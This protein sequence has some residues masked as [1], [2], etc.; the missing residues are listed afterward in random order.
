RAYD[1]VPQ[2]FSGRLYHWDLE[3]ETW[4]RVAIFAKEAGHTPYPDDL[5]IDPTGQVHLLWEWADGGP[6]P[7]RYHGSYLTYDPTTGEFSDI[8]DTPLSVPV[9]RSSGSIAYETRAGV[10]Q[11]A[12]MTLAEGGTELVGVAYRYRASSTSGFAVNWAQWDGTAW[13]TSE[14]ASGFTSPAAVGVTQHGSTV[15]VYYVKLP[16]CTDR[17]DREYGSLY[18]SQAPLT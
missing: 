15:R 11:S 4:S 18:V 6:S 3:T 17:R 1:P 16:G 13:V 5:K 2:D 14:V 9:T 10:V 12:R 8:T 7:D